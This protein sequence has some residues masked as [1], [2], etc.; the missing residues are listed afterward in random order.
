[1]KKIYKY[2]LVYILGVITVLG[3]GVIQNW[4]QENRVNYVDKETKK[5]WKQ[6][7]TAIEKLE[8]KYNHLNHENLNTYDWHLQQ[9]VYEYLGYHT[10]SGP[11]TS[12]IYDFR[13]RTFIP[14]KELAGI[15]FG[16][17]LGS[18]ISIIPRNTA[19]ILFLKEEYA[20]FRSLLLAYDSFQNTI[21]DTDLS[22]FNTIL[23]EELHKIDM[24]DLLVDLLAEKEK[25]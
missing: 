13:D 9:I 17:R 2:I 1:M 24:L 18:F 21:R 23:K 6:Y 5:L 25:K 10:K 14:K 12:N 3:I 20:Q 15:N 4:Y 16:Y 11:F 7:D 22:D 8:E 19:E